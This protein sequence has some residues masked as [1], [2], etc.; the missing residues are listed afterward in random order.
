MRAA[1]E[2]GQAPAYRPRLKVPRL[3][4]QKMAVGR[5]FIRNERRKT[6]MIDGDDGW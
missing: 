2:S 3:A 4:V 6:L 5:R 1:Q